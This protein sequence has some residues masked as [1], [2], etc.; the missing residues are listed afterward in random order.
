M[1]SEQNMNG[2][3]GN[4]IAKDMIL[5]QKMGMEAPRHGDFR[6]ILDFPGWR[7]LF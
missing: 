1:I 3:E 4:S 2:N 7:K 5:H 6:Q